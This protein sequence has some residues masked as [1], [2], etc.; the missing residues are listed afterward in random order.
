METNSPVESLFDRLKDYLDTRINLLKLKAINK[1]SGVISNLVTIVILALL[2]F[3]CFMLLNVGIAFLIGYLL[4]VYY[5][6]FLILAGFYIIV[7]FVIYK[8]RNK[9]LKAPIAS[10]LIKSLLD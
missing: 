6:G 9:W 5:A 7:A 3:V 1:A 2:G 10:M 8:A 4:G